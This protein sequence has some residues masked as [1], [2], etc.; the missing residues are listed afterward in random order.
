MGIIEGRPD[1][2]PPW[3]FR[4]LA[5]EGAGEW[6]VATALSAQLPGVSQQ[7]RAGRYLIDVACWPVAY[8]VWSASTRPHNHIT[9]RERIPEL[10]GAGWSVCY[11]HMHQWKID[12]QIFGALA[13]LWSI[14][15]EGHAPDYVLVS[16]RLFTSGWMQDGALVTGAWPHAPWRGVVATQAVAEA[17]RKDLKR[18]D[19]LRRRY[20]L[21]KHGTEPP[22]RGQRKHRQ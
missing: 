13:R 10:I 3:N 19:A 12:G 18:R 22:P 14:A 15:K 20:W 8:E 11:I 7:A 6:E 17:E 9:Q 5:R 1:L 21:K 16:H 4:P 2:V